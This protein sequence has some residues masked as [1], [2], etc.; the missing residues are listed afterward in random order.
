MVAPYARVPSLARGHMRHPSSLAFNRILWRRQSQMAQIGVLTLRQPDG[1]PDHTWRRP[2]NRGVEVNIPEGIIKHAWR[3][4]TLQVIDSGYGTFDFLDLLW[5]LT[6]PVL[7]N[8]LNLDVRYTF[9]FG[10]P[11]DLDADRVPALRSLRL[12]GCYV[13]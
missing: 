6:M 10:V 8:V 11:L 12:A 2:D 5:E 3:I 13:P 1:R 7:E 4:C 9:M